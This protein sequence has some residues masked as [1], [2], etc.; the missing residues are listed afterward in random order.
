MVSNIAVLRTKG[1]F[2]VFESDPVSG[3]PK[4]FHNL[5]P[6]LVRQFITEKKLPSAFPP[7]PVYWACYNFV[8]SAEFRKNCERITEETQNQG[9]RP[10]LQLFLKLCLENAFQL[11]KLGYW[12]LLK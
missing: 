12:H 6:R 4:K 1:S 10:I 11:Q 8:F 7:K 2:Y 3:F 5:S 9:C